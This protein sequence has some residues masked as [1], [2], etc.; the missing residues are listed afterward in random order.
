MNNSINIDQSLREKMS[1]YDIDWSKVCNQAIEAKIDSF[2][3]N[4]SEDLIDIDL[5]FNRSEIEN[6]NVP[7]LPREVYRIFRQ[8]WID[9]YNFYSPQ[10]KPPTSAQIKQLWQSWYSPFFDEGEWF[11][12]WEERNRWEPSSNM[13][14]N[15]QCGLVSAF[16]A[17]N[18]EPIYTA[19]I[20]FVSK[21]IFDG[22]LL[23]IK[24]LRPFD[25]NSV[26]IEERDDLP[27]SSGIYFVID[28]SK[29]YYIGMSTNINKRWFSHHK[30]NQLDS[31]SN[32]KISY[33]DCLPKHYLKNIESTLI[34]H[35]RPCLNIQENPLYK[36]T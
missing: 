15:E 3:N 28:E 31:I 7:I 6:F 11:E 5:V 13:T 14:I 29:I 4:N 24:N 35:F 17:E 12:N 19:F 18:D 2:S 30:Q 36:N 20:Q 27:E 22:Q 23:D 8:T 34:R 1:Q 26:S 16:D 9:Y 25:F 21:F 32:L 33:I 10:P